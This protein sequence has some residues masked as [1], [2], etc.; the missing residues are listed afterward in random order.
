VDGKLIVQAYS[1]GTAFADVDL[2]INRHTKD[3]IHKQGQIVTTYHEGITPDPQ[4]AQIVAKGEEKVAPIVKQVVGHTQTAINRTENEVG[5]SA[6]GNL[7]ADAQRFTMKTDFAFMNPGGIR[8]DL[9]AGN[10][11]WGYLYTV[12]PFRNRLVKMGLTGEQIRRLLNQQFQDPEHIRI[13]KTSGLKYA[14]DP[15]RPASDQR[16]EADQSGRN[17]DQ[18][19]TNLHGNGQ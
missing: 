2:I 13:L 3:I 17:P 18:S 5:E 10:V 1:Y 16:G 8:A 6:L 9:P 11:T 15:I 4:V 12:Q 7:I 19:Q 14:W